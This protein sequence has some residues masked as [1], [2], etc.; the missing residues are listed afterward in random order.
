ME[1]FQL[2]LTGVPFGVS[3]LRS[4]W[5]GK[6]CNVSR[7]AFVRESCVRRDDDF[8][9]FILGVKLNRVITKKT[10]YQKHIVNTLSDLGLE[11]HTVS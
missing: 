10:N 8:G 6:G 11:N 5:R 2:F 3:A 7:G 4:S 9:N 1:E